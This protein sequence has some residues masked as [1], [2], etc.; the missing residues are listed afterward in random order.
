[1]KNEALINGAEDAPISSTGGMCEG[2]GVGSTRTLWLN[3]SSLETGRKSI[4][5]EGEQTLP[6]GTP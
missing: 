4:M 5:D 3:L 1:M 6:L 2:M